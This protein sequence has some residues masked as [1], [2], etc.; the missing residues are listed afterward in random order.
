MLLR[1]RTVYL[2]AVPTVFVMKRNLILSV[3]VSPLF[4]GCA[5]ITQGTTQSLI[6]NLDPEDTKCSVAREGEGEIGSISARNNTLSVGKDKDDIVVKCNAP[7]YKQKTTR[8]V[9]STQ[10]AGVVG[11]VFLDLGIV[12]MMT[13]AMWAYPGT[14][15]ITLDACETDEQGNRKC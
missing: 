1:S 15:S 7:G 9:S 13:G 4:I 3:L 10:A 5:S 6:F 12:D 14:T 11:G 2:I 8:I